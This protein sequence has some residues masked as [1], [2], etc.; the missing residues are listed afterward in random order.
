MYS[1]DDMH[2]PKIFFA[3]TESMIAILNRPYLFYMQCDLRARVS[4]LDQ[5]S[6]LPKTLKRGSILAGKM[7]PV[8]NFSYL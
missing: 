8:A 7:K 2:R 4:F 5:F 3:N 1:V 6:Y